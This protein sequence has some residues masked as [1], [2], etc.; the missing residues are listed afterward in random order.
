MSLFQPDGQTTHMPRRAAN[1][2]RMLCCPMHMAA[3]MPMGMGAAVA[4]PPPSEPPPSFVDG[5][6][7]EASL[8]ASRGDE[9]T[10]DLFQVAAPGRWVVIRGATVWPMTGDQPLP[11]HDILVQD[12]VIRAVQPSGAA[13]PEA[14]LVIDGAGKHIIPGLADNH[15]H[16]PLMHVST[17]FASMFGPQVTGEDLQLPYDLHMFLY[18]T[19][20]ITRIQAMAGSSEDLALRESIRQGRLRGPSMRVAS[21]VIDGYPLVWG[22]HISYGVGTPEGGR[23]AARRLKDRGFNFAKP[24]TRLSLAAY[25]Q[26]LEECQALGI[27]VTGHIPAAVPVEHALRKGQRG[28]AHVFEYFYN[29][30]ES[31]RQ[32]LDMM[33]RRARLSAE[34]DVT[35]QSTLTVSMM[36][37]YDIGHRPDG[38]QAAGVFDPVLRHLMRPGGP[39]VQM[40]SGNPQFVAQGTD[41][42]R[43]SIHMMKALKAEGVRIVTGTDT[44]TCNGTGP[45]TIH[46]ELE[47]FVKDVGMTPLEA[48]RCATVYS[49]EHHGESAVSGTLEAGKRSDLVLLEADPSRDIAATRRIKGVMLGNAYIHREAMDRGLERA[50]AIFAAMPVPAA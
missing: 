1:G 5:T 38:F 47:W 46:D 23:A 13:L 15:V 8:W 3:M 50:K 30:T 9:H 19:G 24:Y 43:H 31:E 39:I 42:L 33:A 16:P 4:V 22:A 11:N 6:A 48:L 28:V 17:M 35:V 45:H 10:W 44:G 2:W 25:D 7:P 34:L 29:D 40:F 37:E 21:P 26:L 27:E 32:N 14:A 49:A 18:L 36:F 20:G 12:G 41:C